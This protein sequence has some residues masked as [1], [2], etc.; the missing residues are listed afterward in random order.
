MLTLTPSKFSK[1]Y[2]QNFCELAYFP[3]LVPLSWGDDIENCC[4]DNHF[5][6]QLCDIGFTVHCIKPTSCSKYEDGFSEAWNYLKKNSV[7]SSNKFII[8]SE[9]TI[10]VILSCLGEVNNGQ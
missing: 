9:L 4:D 8:A 2:L 10:P 1:N 3:N 7:A 6:S 5:C